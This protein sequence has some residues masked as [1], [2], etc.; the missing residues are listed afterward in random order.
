MMRFLVEKR[1]SDNTE[2]LLAS[3]DHSVLIA[4]QQRL[5]FIEQAEYQNT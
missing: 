4:A 1:N 3:L 2:E 5:F